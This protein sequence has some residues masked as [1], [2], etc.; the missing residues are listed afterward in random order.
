MRGSLQ[1]EYDNLARLKVKRAL[2][3]ALASQ[4]RV[5]GA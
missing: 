1:Q 2:L 3:D 5:P 4:G